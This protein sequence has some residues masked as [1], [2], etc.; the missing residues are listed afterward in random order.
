[1]PRA[2]NTAKPNAASGEAA[3]F[4][5][6]AKPLNIQIAVTVMV[7]QDTAAG[8]SPAMNPDPALHA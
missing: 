8:G 6:C 7:R 4:D 5:A 3:P 1:M 2:V